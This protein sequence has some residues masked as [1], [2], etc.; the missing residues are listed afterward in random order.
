MKIAI[1]AMG[2]DL[3]AKVDARFGRAQNFIIVDLET[4]KWEAISNSGMNA[5][6]GAGIHSGQLMSSRG[7]TVV[8]T[9]HVGPNA[10]QTLSAAGIKIFHADDGLVKQAIEDYQN[11]KLQEIKE[12]SPA[13]S[14]MSGRNLS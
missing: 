4:M 12:I 9:G 6:H 1:T 8:I 7:V 5:A 11:G 13:H 14:G 2:A 10:Y 3:Q